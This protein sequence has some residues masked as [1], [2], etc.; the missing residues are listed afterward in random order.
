MMKINR[1]VFSYGA[2]ASATA[3]LA[4]CGGKVEKKVE[5]AE[6]TAKQ[7]IKYLEGLEPY[8][9]GFPLV[10]MDVTR[11]IT[12][13]ASKSGQYSAPLNQFGRMRTFV[14]PDFKN[15][16]RISV[17]SL[18]TFGFIDLDKEPFIYSQPDTKGRYIVMQALNMWTDDFASVGTRNTGNEAGNFLI[19]GPK[20]NGTAP[21]DVKQTFK[22]ST[23][24]AWVLVQIAA[25]G[26]QD[27]PEIN[28]LQD[29]LQLTPLSAWG[30][31]YTPPENVPVDPNV[32][33]TITP[34]D[35]LRLM[36]GETFFK[37]L[38][39]LLNDN[40]PNPEDG[41]ML[42]KLKRIGIEPGKEFD[43]S[44]LDPA[45]AKG[46]NLVPGEVWLKFAEGVYQATTVNGWLNL[47]NLGRYGT[48]YNTRALVAWLGLGA[49]TSDDAVYPSAFIDG[50]GKV[51]EGSSKYVLHFNK[52]ELPPSESGVWSISQ[53]RENFYVRNSINRY[54]IKS[55]MSLK[56]N[57]DGSL[58]IYIQAR[59]PGAD[60][61]ANW[62]PSPPSM[63]FN[64]TIR[65]YQPKKSLLEG[66]Y[67]IPP[68]KRFQ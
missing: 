49:L 38:A 47:L 32:D 51:L 8:V 55:G 17:N 41:P 48:D 7:E 9:Y 6:Q 57:A 21:S 64:L 3:L 56:Y 60:K 12:T 35:T 43:I 39:M 67:K 29:K 40:P 16:V 1:R 18:W 23:R 5:Q 28:A 4:S 52:D 61:E 46:V 45:V 53:Y 54:A 25:N 13:A 24:Y 65:V 68:V 30:K 26:P 19:A 62:L 66:T 63:P 36:T 42:D 50:D 31:P 2:L 22:C 11:Q 15:V 33:L 59:S 10:M 58:D 34:Y 14:D 20:W 37:R 27:F 44:K